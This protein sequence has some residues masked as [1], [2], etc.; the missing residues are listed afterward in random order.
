MSRRTLARIVLEMAA[1]FGALVALDL[2]VTGGTGF[3]GVE[4]S[5][6]WIPVLAMALAYGTGP[7]LVAAAIAAALWLS[8]AAGADDGGDYL[9]RVFRLSVMPLAWCLAAVVVGETTIL[10]R[11]R[12]ARLQQRAD[13][14][15]ENNSRLID[16][17]E[18]VH[19][20]NRALQVALATH[21][22]TI[23]RV[24]AVATGLA[25]KEAAARR[26]AI[27]ELIATAAGTRDF[28]VYRVAEGEAHAWL[29]GG[30][31]AGRADVLSADLVRALTERGV[32][33]LGRRDDRA[34]LQPVGAVAVAL[35]DEAAGAGC[36]VLHSAPFEM[37]D[38]H[39][40]AELMEI[41]G[42]LAPLLG[43]ELRPVRP[44]LADKV[45]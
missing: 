41:A 5:L 19:A 20:T 24:L 1:L 36:L 31:G 44:V 16:A 40:R 23:G 17:F 25:S 15:G 14:L 22:G 45:A 8:H 37:I 35:A 21:D 12:Y 2:W 43:G 9:E 34:L 11:R 3:V 26:A 4:P 10:R 30:D 38:A 13:R 6:W 7:G 33:H 42:W 18:R 29:R 27:A 32:M 28:S 39:R